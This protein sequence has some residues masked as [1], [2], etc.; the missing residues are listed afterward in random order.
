M[1]RPKLYMLLLGCRPPGRQIEQHDIFFGIGSSIKELIPEM[2]NFWPEA[3][4][5]IHVDA[6]RAITSVNGYSVTV[7]PREKEQPASQKHKLFFINLGGYKPD[8]FD[9]LHYKVLSVASEKSEAIQAAKQTSFFKHTGFK[10]ATS[11]IDDKYGIDV[12][13]SYEINE[14]LSDAMKDKY[15]IRIS[16]SDIDSKD[17]E[18][19]L[20]YFNLNKIRGF[21]D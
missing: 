14:L 6:W 13:D 16:K 20:G 17:D 12:D 1:E 15:S 10:G 9:E 18:I 11:H 19:H 7:V 21:E 4:D 8:E 3:G 5:K 2:M